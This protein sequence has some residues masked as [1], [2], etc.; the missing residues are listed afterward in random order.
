MQI[1]LNVMG[2]YA[3]PLA[4]AALTK[5]NGN[6]DASKPT[7]HI[8][9]MKGRRFLFASEAEDGDRISNAKVKLF[10]GGERQNGRKPH[11]IKSTSFDPSH[12]I[13]LLLNDLLYANANDEAFW[14]RLHVLRFYWSYKDKIEKPHHKLRNSTLEADI[15][16]EY[17]KIMAWLVQGYHK[18]LEEGG[19][20]PPEEMVK[21]KEFYR[22]REDTIAQFV[23]ECGKDNPDPTVE[24]PFADIQDKF[25]P[26]FA[27]NM[28]TTKRKMSG[29]ML[30]R[31]L[32]KKFKKTTTKDNLPAYIGIELKG[33]LED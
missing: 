6:E 32:V 33:F 20:N 9:E 19:L 21:E 14:D 15:K 29:N 28:A 8:Y 26:W 1:L 25:D 10:S 13:F 17:P 23:Y 11:D 16:K 18:Y 3:G 30:G 31:L 22:F 24:T 7:P 4:T 12:T 2:D 5:S 27:K